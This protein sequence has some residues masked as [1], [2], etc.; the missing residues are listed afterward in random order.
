MTRIHQDSQLFQSLVACL[1]VPEAT[2]SN[3]DATAPRYSRK[4]SYSIQSES[5]HAPASKMLKIQNSPKKTVMSVPIARS[6]DQSPDLPIMPVAILA[7]TVLYSAFQHVDHWPVPLV[8]AYAEDL[9]GPRLW[10][11]DDRCSLLVQNLALCH[12]NLEE[13]QESDLDQTVLAQAAQVAHYYENLPLEG[14]RINGHTVSPC[15]NVLTSRPTN[16]AARSTSLASTG[17]LSGALPTD[18]D[19]D[20]DGEVTCLIEVSSGLLARTGDGKAD[21]SSSSSSGMEGAEVVEMSTTIEQGPSGP[22]PPSR[23]AS[24]ASQSVASTPNPVLAFPGLP[25]ALNLTRIR[26]RYFGINLE[27]AQK[28]IVTA[29]SERLDIKSKQNSK[30]LMALPSFVC[31]PAIRRLTA[32]HLERWL[33]SPALSGQARAL[34]AA[35]VQNMRNVDPSLPDDIEA[36]DSI[37]EMRLKANQLNMY[38]ENVT[39]IAKRIPSVTAARHIFLRILREELAIMESGTHPPLP[40]EPMKLMNAV[41]GALPSSLACE[42][43]AIAFLTLLAE[44][45]TRRKRATKVNGNGNCESKR[46]GC[47]CR[48]WQMR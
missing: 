15:P 9:F 33:Q 10:V 42:G 35:T 38:I 29:L 21:D 17:P 37:M 4:R 24:L 19:S 45:A 43:L 12:T 5:D 14:L 27:Y 1:K 8:Q 7:A 26:K 41:Y 25:A 48:A 47:C 16:K 2:D 31:I 39:E 11:D 36:I 30:L 13:Q 44:L 40:T 22:P 18:S 34:F 20:S 3:T 46:S 32:S 28:A 23:T 6:A